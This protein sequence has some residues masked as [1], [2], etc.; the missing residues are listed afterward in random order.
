VISGQIGRVGLGLRVGDGVRAT[1]SV[2][3]DISAEQG[4]VAKPCEILKLDKNDIKGCCE[5][6]LVYD[7]TPKRFGGYAPAAMVQTW[8]SATKVVTCY[9]HEFGAATDDVDAARFAA[10][11]KVRLFQANKANPT[12]SATLTVQAVSGNSITLDA[13]PNFTP[14][15]GDILNWD[16]WDNLSEAQKK[17]AYVYTAEGGHVDLSDSVEAWDYAP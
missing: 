14:V 7:N 6:D 9:A 8:A 3:H 13:A 11:F 1:V 5:I 2:L 17:I 16:V 15:D 10:G 12:V 4:V